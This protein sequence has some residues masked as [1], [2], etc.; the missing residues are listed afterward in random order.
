MI[1][2]KRNTVYVVGSGALSCFLAKLHKQT[3]YGNVFIT[4]QGNKIKSNFFKILKQN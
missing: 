3:K 2:P 1:K 4:K